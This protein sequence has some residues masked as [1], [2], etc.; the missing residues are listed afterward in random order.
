MTIGTTAAFVVV[1]F[2]FFACFLR[3]ARLIWVAVV[4]EKDRHYFD[5]EYWD[6]DKLVL[7]DRDFLD[8]GTQIT[9][10]EYL[11]REEAFSDE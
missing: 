4:H 9:P 1:C 8:M 2:M 11:S 3:L 10:I 6:E 7:D 5:R